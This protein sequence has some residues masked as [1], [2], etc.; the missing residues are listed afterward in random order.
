MNEKKIILLLD[1]STYVKQN[2]KKRLKDKFYMYEFHRSLQTGLYTNNPNQIHVE[3]SLKKDDQP[4]GCSNTS[5]SCKTKK[6]I[7][8]DRLFK[9][10]R[11]HTL[12]HNCSTICAG[13]LN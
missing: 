13:G 7:F 9:E 5:E 11:R 10:R 12:P 3:D 1:T 4:R 8:S 2:M 6:P